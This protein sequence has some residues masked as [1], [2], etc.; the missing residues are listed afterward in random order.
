MNM[1]AS[2]SQDLPLTFQLTSV[3]LNFRTWWQRH[4]YTNNMP[5]L[6]TWSRIFSLII[7]DQTCYQW[8]TRSQTILS[9][10]SL[11]HVGNTWVSVTIPQVFSSLKRPRNIFCDPLQIMKLINQSIRQLTN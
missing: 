7:S 4:A 3:I 11:V 5:R 10:L 9:C 6:A 2:A 8:T 1:G